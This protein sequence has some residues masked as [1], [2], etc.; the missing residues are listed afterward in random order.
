[1]LA[2]NELPTENIILAAL[3]VIHYIYRA[4]IGPLL[5]PSMSPIHISIWC[6]AVMFQL[7]N[8]ISIGGFLAGYDPAI[9]TNITNIESPTEMNLNNVF[10]QQILSQWSR[11]LGVVI[12]MLGFAANIYHD[13][14]LR[15]IRRSSRKNTRGRTKHKK[16]NPV[17]EGKNT[18][19]MSKEANISVKSSTVFPRVGEIVAV[20]NSDDKRIAA[21]S[22]SSQIVMPKERVK[23]LNIV[24]GV[25][26]GSPKT[27]GRYFVFNEEDI[28]GLQQRLGL[29]EGCVYS[30][31]R[32]P[33]VPN[34]LRGEELEMGLFRQR[35]EQHELHH[36]F[37]LGCSVQA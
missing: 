10:K 35:E 24:L 21:S 19:K 12:W 30:G 20:E 33:L 31:S 27:S 7:M 5:N 23:Y 1:M 2:W 8:G 13:E 14:I 18:E 22:L 34:P 28:V 26:F 16:Y 3:F 29:R 11:K 36:L 32:L 37:E 4:I 25:L 15:D 9:T 6:S 17:V